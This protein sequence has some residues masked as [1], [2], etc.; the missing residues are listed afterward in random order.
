MDVY[1]KT[2]EQDLRLLQWWQHLIETKE[3][4]STYTAEARCLSKFYKL[5]DSPRVCAFGADAH[6]IYMAFTLEPLLNVAYCSLWVKENYRTHKAV[7]KEVK[8]CYEKALENYPVLVG[9]TR[10]E[11]LLAEHVKWGYTVVGQIPHM[12]DG[13]TAWIVTLTRDGFD[14]AMATR[15][16]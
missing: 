7:Y 11:H 4:E 6:G 15:K 1:Q 2:E 9:I 8:L 12:I 13:Q 14:A 16:G 5:F 3:L 10:H